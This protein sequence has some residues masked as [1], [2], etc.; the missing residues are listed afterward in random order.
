MLATPWGV[1]KR[2]QKSRRIQN[3]QKRI[4]NIQN[5]IQNV[6]KN[7]ESKIQKPYPKFK[8][9]VSKNPYPQTQYQKF[10]NPIPTQL[11]D[12]TPSFQQWSEYISPRAPDN[13]T[14]LQHFG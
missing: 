2:I 3:I 6:S 7:T 14:K 9:S 10:E 11:L 13:H 4:Q 1:S 8:I 12:E 5:R